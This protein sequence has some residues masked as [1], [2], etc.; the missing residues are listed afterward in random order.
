MKN[1]TEQNTL[2]INGHV[3]YTKVI[4]REDGEQ[5]KLVARPHNSPFTLKE[6]D[7]N[8]DIYKMVDDN[9]VL[10]SPTPTRNGDQTWVSREH[11][12]TVQRKEQVSEALQVATTGQYLKIVT[13]FKK[14]FYMPLN[15]MKNVQDSF[16]THQFEKITFKYENLNA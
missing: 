16:H 6:V 8:V 4:T 11:Y 14:L 13:E 3:S 7:V 5:V 10:C 15:L 1:Q 9:W 12:L 2:H